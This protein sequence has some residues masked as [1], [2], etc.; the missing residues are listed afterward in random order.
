LNPR[1]GCCDVSEVCDASTDD[2]YLT[3][4]VLAVAVKKSSHE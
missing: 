1:E 3:T 2:Q 4:W